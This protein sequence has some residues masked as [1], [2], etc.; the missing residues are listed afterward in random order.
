MAPALAAGQSGAHAPVLSVPSGVYASA[1]TVSITDAVP[2][3]PVYFT[4]DGTAPTAASTPYTKPIS[5]TS[6]QTIE[7]AAIIAGQPSPLATSSYTIV[8]EGAGNVI[9]FSRGFSAARGPI[10]FNGGTDLDGP[11]LQLTN[12]GRYEAG[13]AFYATPVNIQ[14]FTTV[15]AFQLKDPNADGFTFTVQDAGP[16][17]LGGSGEALGYAPIGQSAAFKFDLYNDA[18]EGPNS[19]GLFVNGALPTTP[20]VS[21][22]HS[23]IELHSGDTIL[24][25]ITYDG[26]EL[27]LSLLDTNTLANWSTQ[28]EI[29]LTKTVGS[30]TA[31]VG[32]TGATGGD[33][34]NQEILS[35][36]YVS[37]P[38]GPY[39]PPPVLPALPTFPAGFGAVG[40]ATNGS[41]AL[42]GS[43]LRLTD[44]GRYEAGSA[45]YGSPITVN[46]NFTT[47][48]TF[49]L[50]G[51]VPLADGITFL[52]LNSAPSISNAPFALGDDGEA[53]GYAGIVQ[54]TSGG[55]DHSCVAIK[56]DLYNNAGEGANSTGL[57]LDGALPTT[58]AID[59]DGTGIDLHSGRPFLAH[60]VYDFAATKLTL[61]LTDTITHATW[62]HS[63]TI[64]IPSSIANVNAYVGF[65]GG[66]GADT[67][68]QEIHNWTLTTP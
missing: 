42:S 62:S 28:Y 56:F 20:A 14:T 23:G 41:A 49:Q 57:Y 36:T 63:F 12:G 47:D 2:G 61:T 43:S 58:P 67:A 22:N 55:Y 1:Q 35:W 17:A 51:N 7:A 18:G 5:V 38:P 15:F 50:S 34:A 46:Q 39:A 29:D 60:I 48:F 32:F 8:S 65:T 3:A 31:Y 52:I 53:L 66:T 11:R 21:L 27:S 13:S 6:T 45:F 10:Q 54:N 64:D 25:E 9:D 30:D 24:A 44:G 26:L 4:T 37:G 68:T 40:L 16:K 59:L 33:T 19:T